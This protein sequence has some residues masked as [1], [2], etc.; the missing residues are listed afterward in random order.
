MIYTTH[1]YYPHPRHPGVE[2]FFAAQHDREANQKARSLDEVLN[3]YGYNVHGPKPAAKESAKVLGC[4]HARRGWP[5]QLLLP[6][7]AYRE[8]YRRARIAL[9]GYGNLTPEELIDT[10]P[11]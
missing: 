2:M 1:V 4:L 5:E 3:W 9:V 6:D 10:L 7:G 11:F 8:H